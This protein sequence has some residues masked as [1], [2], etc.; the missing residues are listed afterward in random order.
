[1]AET[2]VHAWWAAEE[3]CYVLVRG[4]DSCECG[5]AEFLEE[6]WY[7]WFCFYVFVVAQGES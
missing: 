4:V 7:A 1:M 6:L 5:F 3:D 2:F